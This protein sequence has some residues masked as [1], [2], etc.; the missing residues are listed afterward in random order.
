MVSWSKCQKKVFFEKNL[1]EE[2]ISSLVTG[3][4]SLS[5]EEQELSDQLIREAVGKQVPKLC[6]TR[7]SALVA[8]L[9]SVMAKYKAI[10]RA[11]NDTAMFK[12]RSKDQC[13]SLY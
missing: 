10:S 7:W 9:S 13:F 1:K 8:T 6:E 11:L 5:Q 3:D 12:D 4:D 2:D